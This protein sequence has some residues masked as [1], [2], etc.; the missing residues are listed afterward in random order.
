[1]FIRL[2]DREIFFSSPLKGFCGLGGTKTIA[3]I[4]DGLRIPNTIRFHIPG[5]TAAL[6]AILLVAFLDTFTTA[7]H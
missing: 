7:K 6:R 2:K 5:L 1:M 4:G 3:R